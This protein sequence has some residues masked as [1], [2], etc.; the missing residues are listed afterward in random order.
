MDHLKTRG[1]GD[2]TGGLTDISQY[3]GATMPTD[4]NIEMVL[5]DIIM[6][7][8]DDVSEDGQ[9]IVRDGIFLNTGTTKECWRSAI[10]LKVGPECSELIKEGTRIGFPNDKG[11]LGVQLGSGG[12]KEH[13]VFLNES[14]MFA[15]LKPKPVED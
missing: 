4:F 3:A 1:Q 5:G 7:K 11:V 6:A 12:K 13:I 10:V 2:V 14:R 8:F 15:I 9:D